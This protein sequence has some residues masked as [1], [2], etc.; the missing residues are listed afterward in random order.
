M[1]KRKIKVLYVLLTVTAALLIAL[2][3][4]FV[5]QIL[6]DAKA[7][8]LATGTGIVD[9]GDVS[10]YTYTMGTQTRITKMEKMVEQMSVL[11][12]DLYMNVR[13]PLDTELSREQAKK[14]IQKFL[15][16]YTDILEEKGLLDTVEG[17]MTDAPGVQVATD[18]AGDLAV[19]EQQE[20]G[21]VYIEEPDFMVSPEDK[22]LSGWLGSGYI[23]N[24]FVEIIIDAVTGL[25][26]MTELGLVGMEPDETCCMAA[27]E[28]YEKVYGEDLKFETPKAMSAPQAGEM[29]RQ[30]GNTAYEYAYGFSCATQD[31]ALRLE[32]QYYGGNTGYAKSKKYLD[33]YG[34]VFIWLYGE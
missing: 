18:Q 5:P 4:N 15:T 33:A 30:S 29:M 27:A 26:V 34:E 19:R 12:G 32:Y 21:Y 6:L 23:Y 24:Q 3:G 1:K 10:P 14:R 20:N 31:N 17:N 2:T 7:A 9:N 13:D 11:G 22:Q 28:A 25:P 16:A 8:K